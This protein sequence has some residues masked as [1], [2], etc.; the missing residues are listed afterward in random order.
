MED[1]LREMPHVAKE[2]EK[3]RRKSEGKVGGGMER[4]ECWVVASLNFESNQ[5]LS[6]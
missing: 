2:R 6:F 4:E 1:W 5:E 3:E